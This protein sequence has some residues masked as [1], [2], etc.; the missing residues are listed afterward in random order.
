M[1]AIR[2]DNLGKAFRSYRSEWHRVANWFGA[3]FAPESEYWA[4]R[5]VSIEIPPGASV[6]VVGRNGAGKSTLLKLL[7]GT[8]AP[9]EGG[10]Q[11]AGRVSAILELGMGFDPELTGRQNVYHAAGLLGFGSEE[12]AARMQQIE[13]FAEVGE[14][15]D[16]PVRTYSSGMQ[17]RVAFAVA[18]A[19]R[20]DV[21]IVDEALSVGDTYFQHKSFDR[22]REFQKRGTTL[23]LVSH[24]RTAIQSVCDRAV[25]LDKGQVV[26]EGD[27][28]SVFDYYNAL[29]ADVEGTTVRQTVDA[30]GRVQTRS[31]SSAA[32]I[33]SV[34]IRDQK[35][36]ALEVVQVGQDVVLEI[37][38]TTRE[39]VEN[40]V[41]GYMIRDRLGQPV[42]GTNTHHTGNA[43]TDLPAHE[44]YTARFRFS[45]ALGEGGY[46]VTVAL[47]AGAAHTEKNYDWWDRAVTFDVVNV[48]QPIF[49]G[50]AWIPPQVEVIHG[51]LEKPS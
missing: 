25:L 32:T 26:K 51:H 28:E 45:A 39:A 23:L 40:L 15:F 22:I 42:F 5:G 50:L 35:A 29:L 19:W 33:E 4:L 38:F 21:L 3:S 48:G 9:T 13:E 49:T 7:T 8:L 11:M 20:P 31:G 34:R 2:I 47:H 27:P 24:D 37:A 10:I 41:V 16:S 17:M 12:T 43:L 18:T 44:H 36:E 6:G 14:H 30:D 46:T 1:S